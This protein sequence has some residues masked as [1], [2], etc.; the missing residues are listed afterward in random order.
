MFVIDHLD[1]L[2]GNYDLLWVFDDLPN[3]NYNGLFKNIQGNFQLIRKRLL[4]IL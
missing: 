2:C 3:N 1:A 4:M